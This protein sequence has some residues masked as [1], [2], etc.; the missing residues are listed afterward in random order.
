MKSKILLGLLSMGC[1]MAWA[2]NTP[3]N[4]S[5]D[6]SG[7]D[8]KHI[9]HIAALQKQIDSLERMISDRQETIKATAQL[10]SAKARKD[11]PTLL[12]KPAMIL[13][14]NGE[15]F[16]VNSGTKGDGLR[17]DD[18]LLVVRHA[19]NNWVIAGTGVVDR[20]YDTDAECHG[21]NNQGIRP[22]D[23]VYVLGR[24]SS[25]HDFANSGW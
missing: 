16:I 25:P 19:L 9:A 7:Q 4:T 15:T 10:V 6:V 18:K 8:R 22:E 21:I 13:N 20:A 1:S 11:I 5:A 17:K 24:R 14:I 12:P 3:P 23:E 2:Q